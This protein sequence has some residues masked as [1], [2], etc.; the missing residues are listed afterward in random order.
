MQ[1]SFG[2]LSPKLSEQIPGLPE[3]YDRDA[4]AI[5]RL[6]VRGI[7]TESE[8]HKARKRLIKSFEKDKTWQSQT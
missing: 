2:A 4:E 5:T 3:Q 8:T 1:I 7:L 6:L